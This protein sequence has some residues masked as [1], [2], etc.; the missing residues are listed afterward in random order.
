MIRVLLASSL[1]MVLVGCNLTS[2]AGISFNSPEIPAETT[3]VNAAKLAPGSQV[4]LVRVNGNGQSQIRVTGEVLHASRDGV[5]LLNAT[6]EEQKTYDTS[7]WG[8]SKVPYVSRLFKSTVMERE[9]LPVYWVPRWS[10]FATQ[11]VAPPP[12]GYVAPQT[13]IDPTYGRGMGRVCV[14]IDDVE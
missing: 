6:L 5:A 10:I 12:E 2:P 3:P 13:A 7:S 9:G 8:L 4:V 11:V 1:C 14:D